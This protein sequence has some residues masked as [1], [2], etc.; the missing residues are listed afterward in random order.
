MHLRDKYL[1]GLNVFY[2]YK[3]NNISIPEEVFN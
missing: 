1:Y 3:F 2:V